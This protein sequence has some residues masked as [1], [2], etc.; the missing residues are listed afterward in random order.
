MPTPGS[1]EISTTRPLAGLRLR[2]AAEQQFHFLV[3]ADQ[4]RGAGTQRLELAERA[5]FGHDLPRRHRRRQTLEFDR[6][7]VPALEQAA[8]LPPGGG[9][10]HHLVGPARPCSRAARFGVSPT[11]VCWRESPEPIGSPMTTKSRCDANA[12]LQRFAAHAVPR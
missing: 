9:V 1:A 10:D 3:A 11:A 8:D 6:A 12:D 4:R 7:E 5:V 2:P